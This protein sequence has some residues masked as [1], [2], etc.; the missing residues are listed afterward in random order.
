MY[1]AERLDG[2]YEIIDGQQR[3]ISIAQYVTNEFSIRDRS[4]H[5][6]T[7]EEKNHIE[8]RVMT[9]VRRCRFAPSGGA[10]LR[11]VVSELNLLG[12]C[13]DLLIADAAWFVPQSRRRLLVV[14]SSGLSE[15]GTVT[16]RSGL[17]AADP[18]RPA[19]LQ[20]WTDR[21]RDLGVAFRDLAPPRSTGAC[22]GGI[23]EALPEDDP[24]WWTAVEM[25][26][27]DETLVEHHRHLL[28]SRSLFGEPRWFSAH[29]RSRGGPILWVLRSDRIAGCL[30]AARGGSNRAGAVRVGSDGHKARWLTGREPARLQGAAETFDVSMLADNQARQCLGDAVCVPVIEWPARAVLRS[31]PG[32]PPARREP[33][34]DGTPTAA[35]SDS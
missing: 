3:T 10:D 14:A 26:S 31:Q 19:A 32:T 13:C 27:F 11:R 4:F 20:Q 30:T 2:T 34:A 29:H 21:N 6:L 9:G 12:Y 8:E 15:S 23:V 28:C 16:G 5:N 1:W 35:F 33:C 22:L 25:A 18:L 24:R 17:M 7:P